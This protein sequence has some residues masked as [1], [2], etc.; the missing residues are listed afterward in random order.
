MTTAT[1]RPEVGTI[2]PEADGEWIVT[3]SRWESGQLHVTRVRRNSLAHRVI[4]YTD[5]AVAESYT[6]QAA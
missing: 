6:G 4:A 5:A 1:E 2:V 3:G